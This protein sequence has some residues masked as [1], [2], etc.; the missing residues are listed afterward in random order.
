MSTPSA[1]DLR[2]DFY[3]AVKEVGGDG[4][5][6]KLLRIGTIV[7]VSPHAK[8]EI[9]DRFSDGDNNVIEIINPHLD[10]LVQGVVGPRGEIKLRVAPRFKENFSR[11]DWPPGGNGSGQ[12]TFEF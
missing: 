10:E 6:S 2:R 5:T 3:N 12:E 11:I 4:T 9:L 8:K 7:P 1:S